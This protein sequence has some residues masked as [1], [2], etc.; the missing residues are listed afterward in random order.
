MLF[1][2]IPDAVVRAG[3]GEMVATALGRAL[4]IGDDL[5][6]DHAGTVDHAVVRHALPDHDDACTLCKHMRPFLH[7]R[8][9][10]GL[11]LRRC[12]NHC[13]IIDRDIA[14]YLGRERGVCGGRR[15]A[16]NLAKGFEI[17]AVST[18]PDRRTLGFLGLDVHGGLLLG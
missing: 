18:E 6:K 17:A 10:S 14:H 13:A 12:V 1:Q 2:R 7:Q 11:V 15:L 8:L 4:F 9:A 5:V 3:L 16:D